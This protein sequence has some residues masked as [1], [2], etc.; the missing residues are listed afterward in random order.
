MR[1]DQYLEKATYGILAILL[2][3]SYYF[4]S[5][6]L[7][8]LSM[9]ALSGAAT[10]SLAIIMIFEKIPGLI[11]SGIIE[12]NFESFQ[13]KLKEVLMEHLFK[14]GMSPSSIDPHAVGKKLYE[15]ISMSEY[16]ILTQ[17]MSEEKVIKL[18]SSIDI[19]SIIGSSMD[20]E[21]ISTYLE[22]QISLLTPRE[23]KNLILQIMHEHLQ[24]L[25]VWGAVFG[26]LMGAIAYHII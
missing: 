17:F 20:K 5:T 23:I 4:Q 12:R 24:F 21:S 10:N 26:G 13:I 9:Y 7:A 6:L 14:E 2:G 22:K 1:Y 16:A 19:G 8:T 3:A 11:G 15:H 18:I 25:V